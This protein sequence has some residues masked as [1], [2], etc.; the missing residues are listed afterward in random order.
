MA[1]E[2]PYVPPNANFADVGSDLLGPGKHLL[3]QQV[4]RLSPHQN[5]KVFAVLFAVSSLIFVVPFGLITMA[6]LP[7]G[8][9]FGSFI[10]LAFPVIYLVFGYISTA[11]GCAI[12]NMLFKYIGGFE[13]ES[14][15]EHS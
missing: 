1:T 4:R 12:Y 15:A 5:A 7:K 10:F 2:N 3:K 6:T 11:I 9:G 14:E 8:A 13:Y